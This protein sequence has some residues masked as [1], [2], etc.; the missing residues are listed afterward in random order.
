[1]RVTDWSLGTEMR[2]GE[3]FIFQFLLQLV[4]TDLNPGLSLFVTPGI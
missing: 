4:K 1:V 3:R 2:R